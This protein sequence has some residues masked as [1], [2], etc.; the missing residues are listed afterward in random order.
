LADRDFDNDAEI[1][2]K[3]TIEQTVAYDEDFL[4]KHR[5]GSAL[6]IRGKSI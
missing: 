6:Q 1:F 3:K 2:W 4:R 5:T